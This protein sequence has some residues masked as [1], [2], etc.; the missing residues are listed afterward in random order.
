MNPNT[1]DPTV[2]LQ[3]FQFPKITVARPM[4]PRPA[5][6]PSRYTLDATVTR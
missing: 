1:R 3:G 5:V 2:T 6:W 4:N